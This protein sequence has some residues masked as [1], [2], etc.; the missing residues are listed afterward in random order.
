MKGLSRHSLSKV[1]RW[2]F[3]FLLSLALM[4]VLRTRSQAMTVFTWQ[5]AISSIW[6]YLVPAAMLMPL[7]WGLE[8]LKFKVLLRTEAAGGLRRLTRVVLGGIASSLL[9]PNRIGE[10]AGRALCLPASLRANSVSASLLGSAFQMIWTLLLGACVLLGLEWSSLNWDHRIWMGTPFWL[11]AVAIFLLAL[12]TLVPTHIRPFMQ[13]VWM[14]VK[15]TLRF[16]V[17]TLGMLLG[18]LRYGVYVLQFALLLRFAG[19][20]GTL[21]SLMALASVVFLFQSVLPLPPALGWVGRLQLAILAGTFWEMGVAV[22]VTASLLLWFINLF[23][24]GLAGAWYLSR[25][26]DFKFS[27]Y[28]RNSIFR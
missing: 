25:L 17:A 20:E 11:L 23:L 27:A 2:L 1:G 7:N 9:L 18:L 14:H 24:P 28:V 22:A 26:S 4:E 3:L 5:I 13:E 21:Q 12:W 6:W 8:S 10:T 16:K 19:A 15:A